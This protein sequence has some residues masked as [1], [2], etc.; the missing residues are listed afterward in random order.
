MADV[1]VGYSVEFKDS[2]DG[3][4]PGQRDS[5]RLTLRAMKRKKHVTVRT[6]S[7]RFERLGLTSIEGR[8]I[9]HW[10]LT[11][12]WAQ[13][14]VFV[15]GLYLIVNLVFASIY[16]MGW[17][18]IAELNRGSFSD[19]FYFSVETLSTVGYG[20]MYPATEFGHA[21]ATL[22][23]MTGTF[24]LAVASGV[25]FVRFSR[26]SARLEYSRCMVLSV[27]DGQPML[28]FRVANLRRQAM[29]EVEFRLMLIRKETVGG[30]EGLH[31]YSLPL[32]VDRVILFPAVLTLRHIIDEQSPLHSLTPEALQRAD[33]RFLVSV[34]CIDTVIP[35]TIQS[36]HGYR[37]R[38]VHFGHRFVEITREVAEDV[39]EVDYGRIS[40]TEPLPK[41]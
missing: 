3:A 25:I 38:E 1:A 19:A 40:E 23:I 17:P 30:V 8:D 10:I 9:Y 33:A 28:M 18:C 15:L 7:V 22:E 20:H 11:L 14:A 6:G 41:T 31:F 2:P 13:F 32:Q 5:R 34:V 12:T 39:V 24:G 21:V 36:H 35:A 27:F 29:V 4:I 26:P 16:F 37:W